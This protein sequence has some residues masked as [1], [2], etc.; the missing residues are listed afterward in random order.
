[1]KC[2]YCGAEL[3]PESSFCTNCGKKNDIEPPLEVDESS[4]AEPA[5]T[6]APA[7]QAVTST[8]KKLIAAILIA[9][10]VVIVFAVRVVLPSAPHPSEKGGS[11]TNCVSLDFTVNEGTHIGSAAKIYISVDGGSYELYTGDIYNLNQNQTY[12][13]KTYAVNGIGLKSAVK[14]YTY[15]MDL[16]KPA[17]VEPSTAP[18]TYAEPVDLALSSSD[19]SAIYY[20]LDG[21]DPTLQSKVYQS[22]ISLPNGTITVKALPVNA[23]GTYGDIS[24]WNY[25]MQVPIPDAV[26]FSAESGVYGEEFE[27]A[28][29]SEDGATIYY[30]TDGTEPTQKSAVYEAP[31]PM[32]FGTVTTV[33]AMAVNHYGMQGQSAS[34]KY[35]VTYNQ[36]NGWSEVFLNGYYY[37]KLN[38]SKFYAY[39]AQG[40]KTNRSIQCMPE[41]A[42]NDYLYYCSDTGLQR[43]DPDSGQTT[44]IF[45]VKNSWRVTAN[46]G[47]LYLL[48]TDG[49]LYV[50]DANGNVF[51][52]Y[53]YDANA[54]FTFWLNDDMVWLCANNKVYR[55]TRGSIEPEE[56]MDNITGFFTG[57]YKDG[58]YFYWDVKNGL[59]IRQNLA[60]GTKDTLFEKKYDK[61][62]EKL[63][64]NDRITTVSRDYESPIVVHNTL[65]WKVV[66]RVRIVDK[67]IISEAETVLQNDTF[68]DWCAVTMPDSDVRWLDMDED[69][70][71]VLDHCIVGSSGKVYPMES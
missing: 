50:L 19:A 63:F 36:R 31:I 33:K 52:T 68:T 24:E 34:A 61:T 58:Y 66:T 65:Y 20:T 30:T 69:S 46:G 40:N 57:C 64:L 56:V 59:I 70:I 1:M 6:E 51:A 41:A 71:A 28:L 8:E 38:D 7:A 2:K 9:A 35:T 22:A 39:D 60:D 5:Q 42:D 44:E 47:K 18:G 54:N 27:L 13:F 21:T 16:P 23:D 32:T 43:V 17:A 29:Q 10:V 48:T 62:V 14:E 4:T 53:S 45:S 3:L 49:D 67:G 11:Y 37:V 12:T 25:V 15:T 26:T 55:F